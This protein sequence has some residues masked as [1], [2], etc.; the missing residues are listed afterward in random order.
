MDINDLINREDRP[1]ALEE[2]LQ[3]NRI[4]SLSWLGRAS[5]KPKLQLLPPIP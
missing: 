4:I 5:R 3:R 1:A 2:Y